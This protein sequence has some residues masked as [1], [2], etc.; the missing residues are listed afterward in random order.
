[1]MLNYTSGTTGNPKGVKIH[2]FGA[3]VNCVCALHVMDCD[4]TDTL[5]SYLPS[6]HAFDQ[7]MFGIAV[8][9][10]A[11]VGYYHGDTLKLTEDC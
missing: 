8:M 10:G 7:I 9:I 5:I 3:V 11:R 2:V 1:M 6:P 4:H